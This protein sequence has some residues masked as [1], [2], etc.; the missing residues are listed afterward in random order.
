MATSSVT[1]SQQRQPAAKQRCSATYQE[2]PNHVYCELG[3]HD[4]LTPHAN[5]AAQLHW[6]DQT[7]QLVT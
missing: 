3:A 1:P 6:T 5:S 2:G 7:G 4:R